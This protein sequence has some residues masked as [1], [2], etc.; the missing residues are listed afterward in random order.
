[1]PITRRPVPRGDL[2]SRTRRPRANGYWRTCASYS[3]VTKSRCQGRM[4]PSPQRFSRCLSQRRHPAGTNGDAEHRRVA[5]GSERR[6]SQRDRVLGPPHPGRFQ[7]KLGNSSVLGKDRLAVGLDFLT[8]RTRRMLLYP[9]PLFL[10]VRAS[11]SALPAS[12]SL[13]GWAYGSVRPRLGEAD[14]V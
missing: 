10:I 13:L 4:H 12:A 7:V 1:M 14:R 3:R 9:N 8:P 11:G 6:K 5:V 2:F